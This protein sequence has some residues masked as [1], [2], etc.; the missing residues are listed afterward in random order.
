MSA[1]TPCSSSPDAAT[2]L[3]DSDIP[4]VATSEAA[5]PLPDSDIPE[6]G[7]SEAGETGTLGP[8]IDP[9]AVATA[10]AGTPQVTGHIVKVTFPRTDMPF[11]IDNWTAM[12]PFMG[13]T[14]Y[15]AFT[16][17]IGFGDHVAV[18]GDL[19]LLEDEVNPA[20]SA[21]LDAGLEV[22][23]LHNHFFFDSPHV[24]FMHIGGHGPVDKLGAAVK[25]ALDA[26]KAV[27]QAQP[28]PAT[29][30]GAVP[31]SG[32]SQIDAAPLDAALGVKGATQAGMYKASFP[33]TI[34]SEMCGGCTLSGSESATMGIYTWAAFGGTN[35]AAAVDG[36][37]AATDTE[38]Q[39]VLKALRAGGINIV[40]IH[41]HMTGDSPRL[42][43][44]HY[45]GRGTAAKLAETVKSAVDLTAWDG[46][47]M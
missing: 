39:G 25:A 27:R 8:M 7:T 29:N 11:T 20:M 12:P 3:P 9:N 22:T 16:P 41:Q 47:H 15:A 6:V 42:V 44:L 1:A 5:T 17:T 24:Y 40:S 35:D 38:L 18:M 33:R 10:T 43:F 37:F 19:V 23:A 36:D 2:P 31:L 30:F 32:M 45:W 4:E 13:L 21:A 14:S 46:R 26:Q 28:M 34:T